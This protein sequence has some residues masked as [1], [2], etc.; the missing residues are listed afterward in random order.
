MT[1]RQRGGTLRPGDDADAAGF[2]CLEDLPDL[3]FPTDATLLARL[4][5]AGG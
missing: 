3:A 4:R 1:C 5:S 2:F